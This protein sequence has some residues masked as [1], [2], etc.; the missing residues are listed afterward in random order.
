MIN[1]AWVIAAIAAGGV[2]ANAA[3]AWTQASRVEGLE[4]RLRSVE[5]MVA[6]LAASHASHGHGGKDDGNK[7]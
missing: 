6:V 3:I 1:P 4:N 5:V 7:S 2:I